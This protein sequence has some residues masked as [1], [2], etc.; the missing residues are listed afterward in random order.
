MIR[1]LMTAAVLVLGLGACD[2]FEGN[3]GQP[4]VGAD[5]DDYLESPCACDD[6]P[7]RY[8]QQFVG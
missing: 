7:M 2:T 6:V 3:R 1:S 8:K 4:D 5:T